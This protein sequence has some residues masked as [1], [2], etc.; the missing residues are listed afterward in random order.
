MANSSAPFVITF[1]PG[2]RSKGG[3]AQYNTSLSQALADEGATVRQI[4][5][6]RQYPFFV[7]RDFKDRASATDLTE[8]YNIP[9]EYITDWNNPFTWGRTAQRIVDLDPDIVLIHWYNPT[10]GIPLSVIAKKLRK[11]G[12]KRLVFDLHLVLTKEESKLDSR[13]TKKTLQYATDIIVHGASV[14]KELELLMAPKILK[15]NIRILDL[16]HPLYSVFQADASLDINSLKKELGLRKHVFLFFGFIR[17]YKG[18]HNCI[19][20]FSVLSKQRNDVSLLICGESFWDTVDKRKWTTKLKQGVFQIA[21]SVL[22]KKK[23]RDTEYRPLNLLSEIPDQASVVVKNEFIPNE[24]VHKYFQVSDAALL[25]YENATPSGVE[26]LAYNFGIPVIAT[27]VGNFGSSIIDGKNGYL[28]RPGDIGHMAEQMNRVITQPIPSAQ[29][30]E[31]TKAMSWANYARA[32]LR[33]VNL[34]S[35]SSV[36]YGKKDL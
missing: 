26:S 35:L 17:K 4:A 31:Q 22:M 1:G 23:D 21:K 8:G 11:A 25:L 14:R 15:N 27:D 30:I 18:L 32:V 20:A 13:L 2:P 7:P 19:E 6:E 12:V 29:I 28:C 34:Q 36:K 10:Q 24:D 3:I 5:W 9:V 33:E 16:F